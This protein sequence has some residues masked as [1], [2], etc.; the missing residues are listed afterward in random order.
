MTNGTFLGEQEKYLLL[1][2]KFNK[3]TETLS[4]LIQITNGAVLAAIMVIFVNTYS[5]FTT[6]VLIV[7]LLLLIFWRFYVQFID[8]EIKDIYNRI[9]FCEHELGITEEWIS[10]EGSL[11]RQNKKWYKRGVFGFHMIAI[12]TGIIIIISY[13]QFGVK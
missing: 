6:P 13:N 8:N 4:N 11:N 12:V 7:Y 2:K 3:R 10:L 9:D 5:N 1:W